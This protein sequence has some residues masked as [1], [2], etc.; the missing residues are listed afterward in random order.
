SSAIVNSAPV[1]NLY[2]DDSKKSRI[3]I[4]GDVI[5]SGNAFKIN[6]SD[7]TYQMKLEGGAMLWN[8]EDLTNGLPT[9]KTYTGDVD[10]YLPYTTSGGITYNKGYVSNAGNY[11]FLNFIQRFNPVH[12]DFG[13]T[14]QSDITKFINDIQ[15]IDYKGIKNDGSEKISGYC[16]NSAIAANGKIYIGDPYDESDSQI[17][18]I[19]YINKNFDIPYLTVSAITT[20]P[21]ITSWNGYWKDLNDTS[22]PGYLTK[23]PW[24]AGYYGPYGS[25]SMEDKV[26]R[27]RTGLIDY[28]RVFT[29]RNFPFRDEEHPTT[30]DSAIIATSPIEETLKPSITSPP[31]ITLGGYQKSFFGD[32]VQYFYDKASTFATNDHVL[33]NADTS[34]KPAI[35]ISTELNPKFPPKPSNA[36]HFLICNFNPNTKIVVDESFSGI[37]FTVGQVEITNGAMFTGKIIAAGKG[38]DSINKVKGSSAMDN[39]HLP[40]VIDGFNEDEFNDWEY[41]AVVFKADS[42]V[43]NEDIDTLL[44]AFKD[45]G[46]DLEELR[47][48]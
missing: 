15:S 44:D 20:S 7:G 41:A 30:S 2:S 47:Q 43:F 32:F 22:D 28:V 36:E 46:V 27:L 38:Y 31:G 40:R 25:L 17:K 3:A 35:T 24:N 21:A 29:D 45:K 26:S 23:C 11:G 13:A 37:I 1:H 19:G 6:P 42:N 16:R 9:Y 39:S 12:V 5:V 4:N 10:K 18:R 8:G 48:K 14:E 34:T 33:Y